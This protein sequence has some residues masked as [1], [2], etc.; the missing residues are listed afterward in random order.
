MDKSPELDSGLKYFEVNFLKL[1]LGENS[2]YGEFF[3]KNAVKEMLTR[4]VKKDMSQI[5]HKYL[6]EKIRKVKIS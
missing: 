5:L 6:R 3:L 2:I 1:N 4:W